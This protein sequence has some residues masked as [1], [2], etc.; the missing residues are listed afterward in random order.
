[1]DNTN[2]LFDIF[3]GVL[4]AGECDVIRR[5]KNDLPEA[6]RTPSRLTYEQQLNFYNEVVCN[7]TSKHKY[8]GI[9]IKKHACSDPAD[10]ESYFNNTLIGMGGIVNIEF[11]NG[12]GEIYLML[13]PDFIGKGFGSKALKL[14]LDMGFNQLRLNNIFG[15]CYKCNKNIGFWKHQITKY[16]ATAVILPARK[17]YNGEYYDSLYFNFN[18]IEFEDELESGK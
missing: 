13:G 7:R 18:E 12:I 9:Y 11:E 4:N 14:L 15:E 5:W 2:N 17:Y 3:L 16:N 10:G 1:M 6:L 8:C